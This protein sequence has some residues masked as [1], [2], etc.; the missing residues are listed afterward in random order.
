MIILGIET[1]CDETS[2]AVLENGNVLSNVVCTHLE[3]TK[4]GGVVPEIASKNHEKLILNIIKKSI[5]DAN[6][7]K[8]D[9]DAIA[10]TYGP[11][12]IG[13]LLVG[14]NFAKGMSVGLK[15]PIIG[16]NHLEGHLLSSFINKKELSYPYLCMLVS[17]GHTQIVFVDENKYKIIANT[18]DDAAGEA[19]DKGARILGLKYPGGPEIEKLS[20]NGNYNKYNF[21]IPK[22]KRSPNAFSFSGLK[23]SLLYKYKKMT[24][25]EIDNNMHHLAA[26]YQE[27]IIDTLFDKLIYSLDEYSVNFVT[28]VG[29]V[30]ANKRFREKSNEISNKY[31]IKIKFPDFKFCTDNAA[32]IAMVG[33]IKYKENSI[34]NLSLV[35]S[36]N[37]VLCR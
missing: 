19:F 3:H 21:T 2:A 7:S 12:L 25:Y 32:M 16:V 4:F 13:S 27:I 37:L 28:I 1:S 22:V 18:V 24:Q 31:N 9:I 30:S 6:I 15:I 8:S 10:V 26:S 33:Y 35:P 34:S 23:T 36:S 20:I 29:G 17:G 11:G 5:E 14:L